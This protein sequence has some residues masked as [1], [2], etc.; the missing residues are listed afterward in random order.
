MNTYHCSCVYD[1][2]HCMT[3]RLLDKDALEVYIGL[4]PVD[5]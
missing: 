4:K 2:D 3:L 1:D 5:R